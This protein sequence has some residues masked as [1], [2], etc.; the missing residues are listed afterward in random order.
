MDGTSAT[1]LV[2][3]A[4]V[5][6]MERK[7]VVP[8]NWQVPDQIRHGIAEVAGTQR[9]LEADGHLV[10]I[11]HKLP[12]VHSAKRELRMFW[13]SPDGKW[14]SDDLG[15]GI[16]ALQRHVIEFNSRVLQLEDMENNA[17][18]ADDYFHIRTEVAPIHR[19]AQ[20]M[21]AAISRAYEACPDDRGLLICRNLAASV[22]RTSELVKD[23]ATYG[24]EY[25]MA[26]QGELQA[27]A[28]H[29]LNLIAAVFFPILAFAAIFGMNLDHGFEHKP[30]WLFWLFV[31]FGIAIGLAMKSIIF[32]TRPK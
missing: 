10:L 29:R 28:S 15:A 16:D 18:S 25:T 7:V 20:N 1:T 12:S 22:E 3:R 5:Q 4:K 6:T 9:V 8:H 19:A 26:K 2:D 21:S 32:R 14:A 31:A 13:R 24:L 27:L 23:D 11:L 30:T 17:T